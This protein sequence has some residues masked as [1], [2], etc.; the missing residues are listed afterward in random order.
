MIEWSHVLHPCSPTK[1]KLASICLHLPVTSL[2][3]AVLPVPSCP[4]KYSV[5]QKL[6]PSFKFQSLISHTDFPT[7]KKNLPKNKNIHHSPL[8]H[9]LMQ[10]IIDV[11]HILSMIGN[12]VFFQ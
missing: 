7:L 4:F 10:T 8:L 9:I 11:C 6:G 12:Y 2:I 5:L 3:M 1:G